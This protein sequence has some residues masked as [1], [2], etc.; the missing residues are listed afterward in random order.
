MHF[1][2]RLTRLIREKLEQEFQQHLTQ[3]QEDGY[4]LFKLFL[5]NSTTELK[6]NLRFLTIALLFVCFIVFCLFFLGSCLC[7]ASYSL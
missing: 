7:K 1:L 4:A 2:S 3:Q 5:S 6:F